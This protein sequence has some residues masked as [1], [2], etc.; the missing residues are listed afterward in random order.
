MNKFFFLGALLCFSFTQA[1]IRF[2]KAF[3]L[4]SY[5]RLGLSTSI[6]DEKFGT[7]LNL[8]GQGSIGGRNEESDYIEL[9]PTI[10][11]NNLLGL[12]NKVPPIKLVLRWAFFSGNNSFIASKTGTTMTE[13]YIQVDSLLKGSDKNLSV[14]LGQRYYRF[15][16][17]HIA[18]YFFFNNYTSQGAGISYRRSKFAILTDVPFGSSGNPYG[19]AV[20][21]FYQ[22]IM[23]NFQQEIRINASHSF[24]LLA[25]IQFHTLN[26]TDTLSV[27]LDAGDYGIVIGALH[28]WT[29]AKGDKNFLAFRYGSGIA[30]GPGE[31]GWSSR[32]FVTSGNPNANGQFKGA[33]GIN[34]EESYQYNRSKKWNLEGYAIYRYTQGA[35]D[36]IAL[37]G[38]PRSNKKEDLTIGARHTLFVTDR[39]HWLTEA[40]YQVKDFYSNIDET[41]S[42]YKI[43]RATM[44]KFSLIPTLVPTGKREQYARPQLR[45]V[46]SIAFYN[47]VAKEYRLS[48]FLAANPSYDIGQYLG[49]KTEWWF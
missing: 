23:L 48:D 10:H 28:E 47:D 15:F 8:K 19:N 7:R 44:T 16:N 34:A 49:L 25:D 2:S 14:W 46:Y 36:P 41:G 4:G 11:L 31:D 37:P 39:F 33:Y 1:Q 26:T 21:P 17:I 45:L 27:K 9:A 18:D 22:R 13:A 38:F 12:E 6:Y 42:Y 3:S 32:T 43:G 5:G 20:D 29:G 24:H 30:N 35:N 40:N